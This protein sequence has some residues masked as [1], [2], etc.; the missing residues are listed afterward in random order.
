M[1]NIKI[2]TLLNVFKI[3]YNESQCHYR[4]WSDQHV[5]SLQIMCDYLISYFNN[6]SKLIVGPF[7]E[8]SVK[9][10][11]KRV[12]DS[13]SSINLI[14]NPLNCLFIFHIIQIEILGSESTFHKHLVLLLHHTQEEAL[15]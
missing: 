1:N 10:K 6:L 5:V 9:Q 12:K 4:V 11:V 15:V 2:L 8:I 3:L 13:L 14:K 7:F